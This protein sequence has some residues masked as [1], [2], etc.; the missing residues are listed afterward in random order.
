MA[1]G[2]TEQR[3]SLIGGGAG[4]FPF[5]SHQVLL[6]ENTI[7]RGL[8]GA[9]GKNSFCDAHRARLVHDIIVY[10]P[11]AAALLNLFQLQNIGQEA[12]ATNQDRCNGTS[13]PLATSNVLSWLHGASVPVGS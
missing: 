6:H 4:L 11:T 5:A 1:T 8:H 7:Q 2:A 9:Q 12:A 13:L 3:S 10:G